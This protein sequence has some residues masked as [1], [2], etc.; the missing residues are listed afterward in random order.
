MK[1][2]N[3]SED[4]P[5]D[6]LELTFKRPDASASMSREER[7]VHVQ[8]NADLTVIDGKRFFIRGVLPLPVPAKGSDYAIGLWVEVSRATFERVYDLWESDEQIDEPPFSAALANAIPSLPSTLG[9]VVTMTL[10][11]PTRRP[12]FHLAAAEHPLYGEQTAGITPH[13]IHEYNAHF[14]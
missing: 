1:C 6:E 11:G 3:C 12:D 5:D 7:Q 13:R 2:S 9:L 8:E 10:T 14:R 4:H